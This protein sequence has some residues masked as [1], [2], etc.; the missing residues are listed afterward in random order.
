MTL[1]ERIIKSLDK[2]RPY[3]QRDGG[4]MEFVSVDENGIVTVRLLGACIGCGLIDYT[5]RG[6]VEAL[7]MDEIP[8]VT[9]VIAEDYD[10]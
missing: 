1:E 3:I 9:G 10:L 6:G 2:I 5:L 8:E 7:L 4:D